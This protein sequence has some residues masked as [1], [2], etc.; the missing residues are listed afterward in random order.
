[1]SFPAK[2]LN[3]PQVTLISAWLSGLYGPIVRS[4]YNFVLAGDSRTFLQFGAHNLGS[5]V[6]ATIGSTTAHINLSAHCLGVGQQFSI[7]NATQAEFNGCWLVSN[8]VDVNNFDVVLLLPATVTVATGSSLQGTQGN[9]WSAAGSFGYLMHRAQKVIFNAGIGGETTA[10]LLARFNRD[11]LSKNP[12][13]VRLEIGVNDARQGIAAATIYANIIAMIAMARAAGIFVE[14]LNIAPLGS[15]DTFFS[16]AAPIIKQ[17]NALLVPYCADPAN[18]GV[19]LVDQNSSL[20]DPTSATGAAQSWSTFDNL[21]QS[22]KAAYVVSRLEDAAL[23]QMGIGIAPL[24]SPS[25]NQS[26]SK[27]SFNTAVNPIMTTSGG[28]AGTGVSGTIPYGYK[29][30]CGG[31]ATAVLTTPN[32]TDG[33]GNNSHAVV[34]SVANNDSYDFIIFQGAASPP[35]FVAGDILWM[36]G[37][38]SISSPT[39]FKMFYSY[40]SVN[41]GS[42]TYNVPFLVSSPGQVV[43][44]F[45]LNIRVRTG[46]FIVPA[47][48]L[49]YFQPRVVS[50]SFS[51]T[52]G[53][54]I[55]AGCVNL[56][57][58]SA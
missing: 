14:L 2:T 6:T 47:G 35:Q 4:F 20:V 16:T 41:I 48:T 30:D 50:S 43:D 10:G 54:A 19:V 5:G 23:L 1:M 21:H 39:N 44:T 51:G 15:G 27:G 25:F 58:R 32:R 42:T 55:D 33:V 52:G 9:V 29:G 18:I 12:Y 13:G 22:P 34:A 31:T 40:V 3:N 24:M 7:S 46:E 11:V 57:K 8:V 56:W 45:P 49:N 38:V 28:T 36:E 37:D 53:A 26:E 17:V